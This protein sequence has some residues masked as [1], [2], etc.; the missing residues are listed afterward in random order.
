[1]I[2]STTSRR[3][4]LVVLTVSLAAALAG[5]TDGGVPAP[6]VSSPSSSAPSEAVSSAPPAPAAP[7]LVPD[8]DAAA[9]LPYFTQI[10]QTVASG[11]D[12]VAGRGYVDAL[13]AGAFDKA[14]MQVTEDESTVGN[15]AESIQFSVRWGEECLI[16]QVGPSTGQPVTTV[17]S[18]LAT[19]GCLI[20]S[21]RTIDW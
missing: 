12:A 6:A 14:A 13:V 20:G 16:G 21:T 5:C 1:M 8:G 17:M 18:G 11:P 4:V 9:N 15:P 3:A 7:A 10:V 2:R 19:G